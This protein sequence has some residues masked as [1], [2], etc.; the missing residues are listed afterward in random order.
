MTDREIESDL[1]K[2]K[3]VC[4]MVLLG[5]GKSGKSTIAKQMRILLQDSFSEEERKTF[6]EAIYNNVLESAQAILA[7]ILKTGLVYP[8]QTVADQITNYRIDNNTGSVLSSEITQAIVN[9]W[10]E[11]IVATVLNEHQNDFYLMD[12]AHYFLS[13]ATRIGLPDYI[14][15]NADILCQRSERR[16]WIHC[17]EGVTSIIFCAAISDYDQVLSEEA[18]QNRLNESLMLFEGI[19]NSPWFLRTSIILFLTKVDV[20]KRKL[21]HVSLERY[22]P[23]YTG[24]NDIEK[25]SKFII[26]EYVR[27]NR[28]RLSLSTPD[29]SNRNPQHQIGLP[30]TARDSIS[31]HAQ[32]H[33][34]VLITT[35]TLSSSFPSGMQPVS[36]LII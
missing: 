13:E 18:S 7:A 36:A 17:F 26:W 27:R 20:F 2:N 19:I 23:G 32:G 10:Q 22:F 28:A 1:E 16:K 14:P 24:G 15:T 21:P 9:F 12:N 6:R 5:L 8:D 34:N 4:K 3:M 35:P 33:Q 25:A 11:P 29:A 31:E 30:G